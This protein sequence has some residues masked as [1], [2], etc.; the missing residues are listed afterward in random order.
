MPSAAVALRQVSPPPV[1]NQGDPELDSIAER[2][3]ALAKATVTN[4]IA[5]GEQLALAKKLCGHGH[6]EDWIE[7]NFDWSRTTAWNYMKAWQAVKNSNLENIPQLKLTDLY[8]PGGLR[9]SPRPRATI[10]PPGENP[11]PPPPAV[12]HA[13]VIASYQ[14][15][16]DALEDLCRD[17]KLVANFLG[18]AGWAGLVN[19]AR[20]D[21][22]HRN[23]GSFRAAIEDTTVLDPD[24]KRR[25]LALDDRVLGLLEQEWLVPMST[26]INVH[27]RLQAEKLSYDACRDAGKVLEAQKRL[28]P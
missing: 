6:F 4:V 9:H 24:H 14:A 3:R 20:S 7:E 19:A 13:Q 23:H 12:T 11:D 18:V 15:R 27:N 21:Y 8:K 26:P 1:V 17:A 28:R 2:I 22:R 5:I 16:I 25:L 10:I